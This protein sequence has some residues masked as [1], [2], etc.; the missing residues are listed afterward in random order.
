M[1][2]T[3]ARPGTNVLVSAPSLSASKH[4]TCLDLLAPAPPEQLD[5]LRVTY[6]ASPAEL[7]ADW[8]DHHGELPARMGIVVVGDQAGL[9]EEDHDVPDSV[10]VTTANPNDPTGLGMRLNN[11][12]TDHEEGIQLVACFDSL[13]ELLQFVDVQSA[14]KFLHML[15]G[16]LREVDAVGHFHVDPAAHDDQT[17]SRLKPLFDDAV[18]HT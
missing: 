10:F 16:Q 13:T 8:R 5:V 18:D 15:A 9:R 1:E 7:V 12:L 11:Y 14:F 3:G 4:E 17:I 6:S 2:Q